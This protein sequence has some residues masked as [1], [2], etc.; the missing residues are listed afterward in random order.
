MMPTAD[1][2]FFVFGPVKPSHLTILLLASP[3]MKSNMY[4]PSILL[5]CAFN[6]VMHATADTTSSSLADETAT[7]KIQSLI[8]TRANHRERAD[9]LLNRIKVLEDRSQHNH[10]VD[11]DVHISAHKDRAKELLS[12]ADTPLEEMIPAGILDKEFL[13]LRER[14]GK[15]SEEVTKWCDEKKALES[16]GGA[17]KKDAERAKNVNN[18]KRAHDQLWL[19]KN[20][21]DICHK[22]GIHI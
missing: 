22:Y 19:A 2:V 7:A 4:V 16:K 21:L 13:E 5:I 12:W 18:A 9:K 8:N 10:G 14:S 3:I 11:E 20:G 1:F 15:N 17:A 6:F